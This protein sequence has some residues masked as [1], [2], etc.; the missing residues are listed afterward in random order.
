MRHFLGLLPLAAQT[1]VYQNPMAKVHVYRLDNGLHVIATVNRAEPR[2][3]VA[4]ATR[5]GSKNDPP[6]NTGLAHYLEHMLFKGTDRYGTKNYAAEKVYLDEIER[7]YDVYNRTSDPQ[8][9]KILYQKI[10]SVSFLAA[11]H[12]LPNE[13]DKMM[14]LLG[15][16]GTNAFTSYEITA[17]INDIPVNRIPLWMEI[18]AERFR[19]P[20]FRLFHTE[21]EAVYE[22]KN[23]SIDNENREAWERYMYLLFPDH[24][25]GTQTT[26]GTIEHLKNPSLRAIRQYYDTYYVPN[27]MV[28]FVSGDIDP[29]QIA[30]WAQKY[31]GA[32][33]PKEVPKF[34]YPANAPV[35][36][37]GRQFAEVTGPAGPYMLMGFRLPNVRSRE[38][39]I[40][41]VVEQILSNGNAGLLDLE[42]VQ[43]QKVKSAG[44]GSQSLAEYSFLTFSAEPKPGQS[45]QEVEKL[46]W[47]V[48]KK[49]QKGDFPA[50]LIEAAIN[51]LEMQE[52]KS[53]RS[54]R[55]RFFIL[56]RGWQYGLSWDSLL[57]R[58][59]LMRRLTVKDIKA[60]AQKYLT[61]KAY[62][63]VYKNQGERPNL[64]KVEKPVITPLSIERKELSPFVQDIMSRPVEP[65]S[66]QFLDYETLIQKGNLHG[67]YRLLY[68]QNTEDKL[69]T[70]YYV[71]PVG[72]FHDKNLSIAFRYLELL[73]PQGMKPQAFKQELYRLG[74]NINYQV[75]EDYTY[76]I[77]SG[78]DRNAE[79][80]L[81][82]VQKLLEN[83]QPD[84]ILWEE[85]R[86]NILKERQDAKKNPTA[87]QSALANYLIWGPQNPFTYIPS[88]ADLE[89]LTPVQLLESVK[90]LLSY[91]VEY[92]YYGPRSLSEVEKAFSSILPIK[93]TKAPPTPFQPVQR[94]DNLPKM[95][96]ASFPMVRALL[97]W[98]HVGPKFDKA[99][100]PIARYF[101]EYFGGGMSA[102]VFQQI[103][104]AK[105]LAYSATGAYQEPSR[106][107]RRFVLSGFISTQADKAH[108]AYTAMQ[109]L[110][111][112]LTI[113]SVAAQ[114]AKQSLLEVLRTERI[115]HEAI[116]T[117]YQ[118]NLRKGYTQDPR[119]EM[120]QALEKLSVEDLKNFYAT[121]VQNKPFVI[122]IV[123]DKKRLP[124][125]SFTLE[126]KDISL[127]ELFGY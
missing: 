70:F 112:H 98:V 37:K 62:V 80:I 39:L 75:Q 81:A 125:D 65:T 19:N 9:R 25:Y 56:T 115:T 99:L 63:V 12:A 84:A 106:P 45:L 111:D 5:A 15:A 35:P 22:E 27:N 6:D 4:L 77:V 102:V 2:A 114:A 78:L 85:L 116:L 103:R 34:A 55:G 124:L 54:N 108:Q 40:L 53:W 18:E 122:G 71:W 43:T 29:Q 33:K 42:L 23:I 60:F 88:Q 118:E 48:I 126:R 3:F 82:L 74:G 36:Y 90:N 104:E 41:P 30:Q 49:L 24:P 100:T 47:E 26:I 58:Y 10:D 64:P 20:V 117:S 8:A 38:A 7:L 89:A 31:F 113:D 32:W 68:V 95:Y 107:D 50:W 94:T 79:K 91:P 11:Q 67:R 72:K 86:K 44:A 1:L 127:E 123:G 21:L 96:L 120:Y 61:P 92:M 59:E 73:A 87:I 66:P 76:L 51:D 119:K 105:G 14:S 110:W 93:A 17:Y 83:P 13:Y 57:N 101:T 52:M 69:F 121:Y 16:T 28:L 46:L 97:M 109:E